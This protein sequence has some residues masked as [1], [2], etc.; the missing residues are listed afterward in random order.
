MCDSFEDFDPYASEWEAADRSYEHE[1]TRDIDREE[2]N[3]G[4]KD[5]ENEEDEDTQLAEDAQLIE[6]EYR[7]EPPLPP[8]CYG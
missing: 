1:K 7:M 6:D 5:Q 2:G 3:K 8:I 4:H